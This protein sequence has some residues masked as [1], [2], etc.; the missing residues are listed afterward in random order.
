MLCIYGS[1][2]V[3]MAKLVL[4]PE[5]MTYYWEKKF[6][7]EYLFKKNN[8]TFTYWITGMTLNKFPKGPSYMYVQE[9]LAYYINEE[10]YQ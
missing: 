4:V 6:K 1:M 7:A 8:N 3:Q 2:T 5:G 10:R 9:K